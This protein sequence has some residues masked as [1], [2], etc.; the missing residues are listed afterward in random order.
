MMIFKKVLKPNS[1]SMYYD[2]LVTDLSHLQISLLLSC[3]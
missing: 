3:M 2:I 1:I